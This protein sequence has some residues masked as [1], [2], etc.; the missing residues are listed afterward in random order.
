MKTI[1]KL[2]NYLGTPRIYTEIL[3]YLEKQTAAEGFSG[4]IFSHYSEEDREKW[5]LEDTLSVSPVQYSYESLEQIEAELKGYQQYCIYE[6]KVLF[7]SETIGEEALGLLNKLMEIHLLYS[8]SEKKEAVISQLTYSMTG[9]ETIMGSILEPLVPDE[10]LTILSDAFGELLLS[11]SALYKQDKEQRSFKP[12]HN[13]GFDTTMPELKTNERNTSVMDFSFPINL[14]KREL[15]PELSDLNQQYR[16]LF[17]IPVHIHDKVAYFIL[18]AKSTG[19][20]EEEKLIINSLSR[21]IS[22][23]IEYQELQRTV[24]KEK[25]Q[26]DLNEFKLNT[27]NKGLGYLFTIDNIEDFSD[28]LVDMIKEIFKLDDVKLFVRKSWG[29]LLWGHR[30]REDRGALTIKYPAVWDIYRL[31]NETPDENTPKNNDRLEMEDDFGNLKRF[32][33]SEEK[34]GRFP[35]LAAII[36]GSDGNIL[37]IVF[38]YGFDQKDIEFLTMITN[39]AGMALGILLAQKDFNKLLHSY[40]EVME[41]FQ[42]ANALYKKIKDCSGVVEFYNTMKKHLKEDFGIEDLYISFR[43]G[44]KLITLPKKID[45]NLK[46][47]FESFLD[48]KEEETGNDDEI[49]IREL[50]DGVILFTLKIPVRVKEMILAFSGKDN[51]KLN[52]MLQL[53][54]L[55]FQEKLAGILAEDE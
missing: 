47:Y 23:I 28:S 55:G 45:E 25:N 41:A 51:P 27:L 39:M 9:M 4:C 5:V 26:I 12:V 7:S 11:Y 24:E 44:S 50:N 52:V 33:S 36:R 43:A 6:G 2:I 37:G 40:E 49:C 22:K 18:I 53:M 21:L 29:N 42:S 46:G 20:K 13:H 19:Y 32:F 15:F 54:Q 34:K 48:E 17:A 3:E 38:L 14:K 8:L 1:K 30:L 16:S 10:L 35:D 31:G